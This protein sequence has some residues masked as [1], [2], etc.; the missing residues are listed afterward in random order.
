M[1]TTIA[2]IIGAQYTVI[3]SSTLYTFIVEIIINIKGKF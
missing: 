1:Q 3:P 2:T